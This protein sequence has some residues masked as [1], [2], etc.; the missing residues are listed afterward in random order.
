MSVTESDRVEDP[1]EVGEPGAHPP[2]EELP[3]NN[4]AA[5]PSREPPDSLP[6]D[7]ARRPTPAMGRVTPRPARSPA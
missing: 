6:E 7:V 3:D 5:P 2:A 1:A 4:P